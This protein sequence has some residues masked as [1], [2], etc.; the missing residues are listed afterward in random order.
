MTDDILM[1]LLIAFVWLLFSL[2]YFSREV[3]DFLNGR[4]T[5]GKKEI[6]PNSTAEN[7]AIF[8]G[9]KTD[10]SIFFGRKDENINGVDS[11]RDENIKNI[12]TFAEENEAVEVDDQDDCDD[13]TDMFDLEYPADDDS[14][15][16]VSH[17]ENENM[18]GIKTFGELKE[19][20]A[21]LLKVIGGANREVSEAEK[22]RA[23]ETLNDL[24]GTDLY[25]KVEKVCNVELMRQ[26]LDRLWNEE[27]ER[28]DKEL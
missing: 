14:G 3:S 28:G 5:R 23:R 25:S 13:L 6:S 20:T 11:S 8:G 7:L 10:P 27:Y 16:A 1:I 12:V 21:N 26:E 19:E 22:L 9:S 15:D 24:R 2:L 17:E 4:G 18:R